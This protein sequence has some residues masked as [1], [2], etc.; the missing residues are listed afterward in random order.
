M[1][2]AFFFAASNAGSETVKAPRSL[3]GEED[4]GSALGP[5]SALAVALGE[6]VM[7]DPASAATANILV[8]LCTRRRIRRF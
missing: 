4:A 1:S 8:G 3:A 7:I 6:A 2:W 5:G